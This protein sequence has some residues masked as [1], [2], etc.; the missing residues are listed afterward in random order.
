M[1]ARAVAN[2]TLS[3]TN[4]RGYLAMARSFAVAQN[5]RKSAGQY[6]QLIMLD[7]EFFVPKQERA[8][9]L[10]ADHQYSGSRSQYEAMQKP[11]PDEVLYVS[12]TTAVERDPKARAL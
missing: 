9:V 2:T 7:P 8:L 3:P 11:T 12:L 5:Y 1:M 4:V 6:D 10:Y